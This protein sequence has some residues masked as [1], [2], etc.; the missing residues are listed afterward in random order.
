MELLKNAY[1]YFKKYIPIHIFCILLGLTRMIIMLIQPQI[2]SLMVDRVIQPMFGVQSTGNSSIF[3][4][5]I[6]KYAENEYGNIFFTLVLLFLIFL[7]IYFVTF[8]ARWNIVHYISMKSSNAMK[9]E[10]LN[11][12]NRSTPG[13]LKGYTSG[14]LITFVNSDPENVKNL[15]IATIPFMIDSLFYIVVA[16]WFLS[17]M[18]PFLMIF[19]IITGILFIPLT[20]KF[21]KKMDEL[22]GEI[23][24]RNTALN[25]TV[26]ESIFGIR[27]I[28][29]YAKEYYQTDKFKKKNQEVKEIYFR[30]A[31]INSNYEAAYSMIEYSLYIIG[32]AAGIYLGIHEKLTSGEVAGYLSYML[33][34]AGSFIG[35]VFLFADAQGSVVSG[36]RLFTFLQK[37]DTAA[38][39]YGIKKPSAHPFIEVKNL[40]IKN[41]EVPVLND[42]SLSI[43]YGK[44]I[45]IMGKNGSGKSVLIKALQTLIETD[46]GDIFIDGE[47][48]HNYN[49]EDIFRIFSYGMQD[50]FLFSNTIAANIAMYDPECDKEKIYQCGRLA[51]VDEFTSLFQDGY[52]TIVGEKGFGLS[53]GQK[54]RVAIARALLKDAPIL[55]LDDCTSALD[56]ETEHK[57]FEN[58]KSNCYEKTQIIITHRATALKDC[59]EI[60]YLS[61]G[62]ITERGRFEKLMQLNGNYAEIYRRQTFEV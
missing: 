26:Q 48:I 61:D 62:T 18:N 4:F 51:E 40:C 53:G 50:I 15:F 9:I 21:M 46:A 10:A 42:I 2:I 30:F 13:V 37:E 25:T 31:D 24:K 28:Q 49:R 14:E 52:D 19:P 43:P 47:P 57:I 8:Y 59:D 44:K 17:R 1:P 45:G 36:K 29:S 7:V 33:Q 20:R 5:T 32:I 6:E 3:S 38:Q 56:L 54:Q 12:I 55:I 16:S 58:L 23:W 39:R 41:G 35:L 60:L 22:Y 11:K 27:T 34:I